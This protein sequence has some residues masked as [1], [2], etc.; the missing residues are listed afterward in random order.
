MCDR[1][2]EPFRQQSHKFDGE[3]PKEVNIYKAYHAYTCTKKKN[4]LS[5]N[6]GNIND[7]NKA[8]GC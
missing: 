1:Q 5:T 4:Y 6:R 8:E 3:L 2:E 7:T